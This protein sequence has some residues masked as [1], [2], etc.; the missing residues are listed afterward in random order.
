MAS[1]ARKRRKIGL[2]LGS[3]AALGFAHIGALRILEKNGIMPDSI[4]GCSVGALMGALYAKGNSSDDIIA[5]VRALNLE[6]IKSLV[7]IRLHIDEFFQGLFG[8]LCI[9]ELK[10]PLKIVAYD[11]ITDKMIVFSKGPVWRAVR[12]SLTVPPFVPPVKC[13]RMLLIDGSVSD[14]LPVSLLDSRD[15]SAIIAVDLT[16]NLRLVK[17]N[18]PAEMIVKAIISLQNQINRLRPLPKNC[19]VIAPRMDDMDIIRFDRYAKTMKRGQNAAAAAMQKI[20]RLI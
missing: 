2:V 19:V 13:G 11:V 5:L 6:K 16:K 18:N 17:K 8:D 3:G 12:A 4:V 1:I 9:E 7:K 15:F 20:R 10:I 14:P